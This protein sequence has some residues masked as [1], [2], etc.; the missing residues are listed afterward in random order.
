MLIRPEGQLNTE[1][2]W[3]NIGGASYPCPFSSALEFNAPAHGVWNI[4]HTGMLIPDS[5]QIYVCAP[6]CMRGVVLTAAE[7]NALDRFSQ[8]IIKEE[9][10]IAGS[11]EELTISGVCDCLNKLPRLP[12]AVL[13]FTVCL[14]HFIGCD[15]D[16]IYKNL[17]ERFP[18]VTFVRCFMDPIM[19]KSGITPDQNIRRSLY[20]PL[21]EI[22][23]DPK[24]VSFLGSDFALDEDSDLKLLLRENGFTLRE[25]PSCKSYEDYLKMAQA[26]LFI[27]SYPS[28][29]YGAEILSKRLS[30]PCL[31]LPITFDFGEIAAN[32]ALLCKTLGIP[33]GNFESRI[34]CCLAALYELKD[35]IKDTPV[36]IDY[37]FHPRPLGLSRLLLH[38]GFNV[39]CVYLDVVSGEEE[40]DFYYLKENYPDLMLSSTSH[41]K[42]RLLHGLFPEGTLALGQ[43]AA[44]FTGS[45]HFVN[46]VE[47]AGWYGFNGILKLAAAMKDAYLNEKEPEKYIPLKGLGCECYL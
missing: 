14:H 10:V 13:V 4:V 35:L 45:R 37:T 7:M 16:W 39:K 46:S 28:A 2:A 23:I 29:G 42:C 31:H 33:E 24:C 11:I 20:E 12:K 34:D 27:Y 36:Y 8:V 44:F 3:V 32:E 9:D 22:P 19:K 5:H 21:K 15:L 25:L 40:K 1:G 18:E 26:R 17:N 30:R 47:G 41:P 38:C 6:N 43:K